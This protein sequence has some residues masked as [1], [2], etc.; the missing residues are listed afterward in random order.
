MTDVHMAAQLPQILEGAR[1]PALYGAHYL[2]GWHQAEAQHVWK[3][4]GKMWKKAQKTPRF[5]AN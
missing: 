1:E 3:R 4:V 2:I 5:W